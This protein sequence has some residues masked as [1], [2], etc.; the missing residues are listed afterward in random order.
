M[1]ELDVYVEGSVHPPAATAATNELHLFVGFLEDEPIATA[2]AV[3]SAGVTDVEAVTTHPRVRRRGV[4]GAMVAACLS[5]APHLPTALSATGM[6][7]SLY[8]SLGF[9]TLG[10]AR[11][12]SRPT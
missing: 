10:P 4:G 8:S 12:W 1:D 11:K 2:I 6:G 9:A 7:A 5:I 3:E